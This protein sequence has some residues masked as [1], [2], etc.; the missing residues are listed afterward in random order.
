MRLFQLVFLLIILLTTDV[1][2][3]KNMDDFPITI[4]EQMPLFNNG[5]P[6]NFVLWLYQNLNL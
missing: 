1:F 5:G 2:A 4:V 3:Q 6:E